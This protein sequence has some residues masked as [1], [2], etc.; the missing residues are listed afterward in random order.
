MA[1]QQT[2]PTQVNITQTVPPTTN[3]NTANAPLGSGSTMSYPVNTTIPSTPTPI[4]R[5]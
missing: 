2:D 1:N 5:R 3:P 4:Y